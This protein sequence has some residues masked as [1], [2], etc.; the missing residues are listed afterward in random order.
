MSCFLAQLAKPFAPL[1]EPIRGLLLFL[2]RAELCVYPDLVAVVFRPWR[3]FLAFLMLPLMI[4]AAIVVGV[5]LIA[6][7]ADMA[8]SGPGAMGVLLLLVLGFV[9][10][11]LFARLLRYLLLLI[12]YPVLQAI[13]SYI[14]RHPRAMWAILLKLWLFPLLPRYWQQGDVAQVVRVDYS[15]CLGCGTVKLILFA[16][17]SALPTRPGCAMLPRW[18]APQRRVYATCINGT[19]QEADQA[20]Q[21]AATALGA[22][23]VH[24]HFEVGCSRSSQGLVL[25]TR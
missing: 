21:A 9:G 25:H 4:L 2:P 23:L 1:L 5:V 6:L 3:C 7:L 8:Q 22:P 15:G 12:L 11:I 10:L 14:R 20:A 24:A 16:Q 13:D 19:E 17:E 18:I